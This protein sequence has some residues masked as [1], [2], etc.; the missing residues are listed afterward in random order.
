[1][2]SS[3]LA[4]AG[5]VYLNIDDGWQAPKRDAVT[6]RLVPDPAKFPEGMAA[7]ADYVHARGPG[8]ARA[9]C[10]PYAR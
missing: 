6:Q 1:M 8:G 9:A 10:P 5:Y 2:V 7:L 4:D 3:G